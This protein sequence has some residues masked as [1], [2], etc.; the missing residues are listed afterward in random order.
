MFMQNNESYM[1]TKMP[2]NFSADWIY[3]EMITK[4]KSLEKSGEWEM[5]K[6]KIGT[7]DLLLRIMN[8]IFYAYKL[9][10]HI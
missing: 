8:S 1:F 3:Q 2:P 6:S 9:K 5:E 7:G 4:R 10:F